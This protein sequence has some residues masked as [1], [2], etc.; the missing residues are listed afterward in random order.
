[1]TVDPYLYPGTRVLKNKLGIRDAVELDAVE[2]MLVTQR[3]LE[4]APSGDFDLSHL[5]KIHRHLFQDVYSW[6]GKLRTLDIAKGDSHFHPRR[7][8]ET[9][10][11][12]VHRRLI[13][14]DY[15]RRLTRLEFA[16]TAADIIGD[17]NLVHPFREGNGRS[18]VM[19]LVK[20]AEF[21]GHSLDHGLLRQR[22]WI[23]ASRRAYNADYSLMAAEIE[24]ALEGPS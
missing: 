16:V 18:Q 8:I 11:A 14:R 22:Q 23:E 2:R 7:Y 9:G 10:M 12:D 24:H 19:Y 21:A 20:L 5:R 13:S 3:M 1:M 4:G 15:L 6:A 17:V